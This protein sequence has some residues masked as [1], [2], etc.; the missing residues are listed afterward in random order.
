M[1]E[2]IPQ[3]TEQACKWVYEGV[4]RVLSDWFKV[5][6]EPPTL[7]SDPNRPPDAF[8]PAIGF[9]KLMKLQFWIGAVIFDLVL[10][11]GWL[12]LTIAVPVVGIL[13]LV[14]VL[15]IAIVPDI[16]IYVA[17]HLRYDTTWYVMS[18]RS[19]RIRRGIWII[20]EMTFTFE[21]VQN[22]KVQQGPIQRLFGISDLIL[23]TAG[24]G[25]GAGDGQNTVVAMN[26]GRVEGIANAQA[27][28]DRVLVKL[29]ATQTAGIG[30]EDDGRKPPAGQRGVSGRPSSRNR[31][32]PEH[33]RVLRAIRDEFARLAG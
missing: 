28:R 18:D 12:I 17:V 3:R 4:W 33:L 26:V 15:V 27:L 22:V 19:I 6:S 7:P 20:R 32:N 21:N 30:D 29:Q 8:K 11:I 5:P 13:L 24:S 1:H 16:L 14:P 23:E 31:V 25:G 2:P 9:L 10:M